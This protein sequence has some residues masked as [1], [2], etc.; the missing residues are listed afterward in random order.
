[1][2]TNL[3]PLDGANEQVERKIASLNAQKEKIVNIANKNNVSTQVV[4]EKLLQKAGASQELLDTYNN[5]MATPGSTTPSDIFNKFSIFLVTQRVQRNIPDLLKALPIPMEFNP[6][7]NGVLADEYTTYGVADFKSGYDD[8]TISDWSGDKVEDYARAI[9][10]TTKEI[11][12]SWNIYNDILNDIGKTPE[13]FWA[14]INDIAYYVEVPLKKMLYKFALQT[15]INPRFNP[16]ATKD[17]PATM[18]LS[19]VEP[20]LTIKATDYKDFAY[21]LKNLLIELQYPSEKTFGSWKPDGLKNGLLYSPEYPRTVIFPKEFD[22]Q[23]QI[24]VEAGAFN[25]GK[26]SISKELADIK[27]VDYGKTWEEFGGITGLQHTASENSAKFDLIVYQNGY[28]EGMLH[29]QA[30]TM[31]PT[32]KLYSVGH[33][34]SRIGKANKYTKLFKFIRVELG[35]Q[36]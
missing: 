11:H 9:F 36:K 20:D 19:K 30:S 32:T 22:N 3:T 7:T 10:R 33:W 27:V 1:M 26:V 25:L 5:L 28:V 14:I 35:A 2:K 12:K 8:V 13:I 29:Y 6:V 23:Y 31:T 17:I 18:D 15:T 34:Y 24:R 16:E 21:Q 4:V